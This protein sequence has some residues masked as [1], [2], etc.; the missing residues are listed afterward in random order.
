MRNG[1][2]LGS[3][4]C[5]RY[6]LILIFFT[7]GSTKKNY[8]TSKVRF[9]W[10]GDLS[11]FLSSSFKVMTCI[12]ITRITDYQRTGDKIDYNRLLDML[13]KGLLSYLSHKIASHFDVLIGVSGPWQHWQ[14]EKKRNN[15]EC[16]NSFVCIIKQLN[17]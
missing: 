4:N 6:S 5:V 3:R 10:H 12:L 16:Q 15:Q 14:R 2:C 17:Y 1:T 11:T 8:C 7:E 13:M 9:A